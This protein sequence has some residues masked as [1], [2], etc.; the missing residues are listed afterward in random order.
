MSRKL[1][2]CVALLE[3]RIPKALNLFMKE[4]FNVQA[5]KL[6]KKKI[7]MD[8]E[9]S[10]DI[11]TYAFKYEKKTHLMDIQVNGATI[12]QKD[13]RIDIISV[14]LKIILNI[15]MLSVVSKIVVEI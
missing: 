3:V 15:L 4:L 13:E 7:S 11:F 5:E 6:H 9:S 1:P 10:Y 8:V 12:A 14:F 2:Y